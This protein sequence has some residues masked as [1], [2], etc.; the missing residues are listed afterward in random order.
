MNTHL[1]HPRNTRAVS[2]RGFTLI[3]LLTVIAI[4]GIL[5]A[6]LIPV[7]ARALQQA[8]RTADAS[9]VRQ[10]V[11]AALVTA[12]QFSGRLPGTTQTALDARGNVAAGGQ[13]GSA[14]LIERF[15][16]ALARY[17]G[18]NDANLWVS[19]TDDAALADAD[20]AN[21]T[22]IVGTPISPTADIQPNFAAATLS[23]LAV[24][25]LTTNRAAGTPVIFTRGLDT[26]GVWVAKGNMV[27]NS[28]YGE[29]GGHIGFLGGKVEFFQGGVNN[30]LSDTNGQ[31]T[32]NVLQT[33][34]ANEGT[35]GT[36]GNPLSAQEGTP[37]APPG[38]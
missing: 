27:T 2:R 23:F 7:G 6:I 17:G 18:L 33:L 10:L 16:A 19:K 26:N 35:I 13:A 32:S 38:P 20:N 5:T 11:Q 22:T 24:S 4:I 31:P 37:P 36:A 14:V 28:V 9:N 29:E 30:A 12:N 15:A 8:Q 1:R 21:L 34:Y 3:E 25:G